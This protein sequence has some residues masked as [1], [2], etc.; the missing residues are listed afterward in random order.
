MF[1]VLMYALI[2]MVQSDPDHSQN[3]KSRINVKSTDIGNKVMHKPV[4]SDQRSALRR[5]VS[6][7]DLRSYDGYSVSV[8]NF[9]ILL[10]KIYL[11]LLL[12]KLFSIF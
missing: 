4:A 3:V 11:S 6:Q 1:D 7:K 5:S 12:S 9:W 8:V 2:C 10:V